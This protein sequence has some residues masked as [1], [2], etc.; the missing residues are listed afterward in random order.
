METYRKEVKEMEE[1]DKDNKDQIHDQTKP[2]NRYINFYRNMV[3]RE[4][5]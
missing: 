5:V 1:R 3:L 2:V 4:R